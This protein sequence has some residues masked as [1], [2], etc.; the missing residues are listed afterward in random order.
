[1]GLRFVALI[2]AVFV[3]AMISGKERTFSEKTLDINVEYFGVQDNIDIRSVRP[4]KVRIKVRATSQV[5]NKITDEDFKIR[6]DLKDI[7]EGSHNYWT[8]NYLQFPE[9]VE[10][11]SIQQ[12]MIEV[13]VKEFLSRE[14]PTRV[15]YKGRLKPGIRLIERKI[16][17]EKVRIFGYKSQVE[18]LV[19]IEAEKWINLSDIEESTVIKLQLKKE[20][21]VLKF[22]DTDSVE[23]HIIVENLNKPKEKNGQAN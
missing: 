7:S 23:V 6:I 18:N 8:E 17:P 14:V 11:I 10:I 22:E 20:N 12:K 21:E 4:E 16:V 15:R 9:G 1:M 13:T 5:L 3:W 19:E 2:L